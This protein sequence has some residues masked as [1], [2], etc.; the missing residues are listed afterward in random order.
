LRMETMP[1]RLTHSANPM[2]SSYGSAICTWPIRCRALT[3]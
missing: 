1:R 2:S 3:G